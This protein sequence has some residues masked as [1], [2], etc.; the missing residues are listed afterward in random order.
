MNLFASKTKENTKNNENRFYCKILRDSV[1]EMLCTRGAAN[2]SVVTD[3]KTPLDFE[4]LKRAVYEKL[5]ALDRKLFYHGRSH[6]IEDVLPWSERLAREEGLRDEEILIVKTAALFHDTGFLDQYDMNEPLGANLAREMLPAY[7]Y[8]PVHIDKVAQCIM[9]TQLP[10]SPGDNRLAQCLCDADLAHVG[11][12]M[13]FLRSE[14]LRLELIHV[15]KIPADKLT[16]SLWSKGNISFLENHHFHTESAKRLF[17]QQKE[18]NLRQTRLLAAGVI[19]EQQQQQE[20][21][22]K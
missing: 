15:K 9:A 6:T 18:E 7:G 4:R 16:P 2:S 17:S 22:N 5:G 20:A 8:S 21:E 13:Y 14:A 11:T 12:D 10:Q 19:A 1:Y 3:S